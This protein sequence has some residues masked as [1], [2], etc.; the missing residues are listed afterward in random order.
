MPQFNGTKTTVR[1]WNN[2]DPS[3]CYLN[4][5]FDITV[6][7]KD[8]GE[9]VITHHSICQTGFDK[10]SKR[11]DN[12]ITA[13]VKGNLA[14]TNSIGDKVLITIPVSS[15]FKTYKTYVNIYL[16]SSY[17]YYVR[18]EAM[19][20]KTVDE[21]HSVVKTLGVKPVFRTPEGKI[22]STMHHFNLPDEL[23]EL[24]EC[25]KTRT[26]VW[27][28]DCIGFESDIDIQQDHV[29]IPKVVPTLEYFYTEI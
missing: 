4:A 17:S 14:M 9:Y 11:Q 8:T 29:T 2:K 12:F 6:I 3:N 26:S 19:V 24:Y 1:F 5:E 23:Q 10:L 25:L 18:S 13:L 21:L 15:E 20:N 7:N 27:N 16:W 28:E 22:E